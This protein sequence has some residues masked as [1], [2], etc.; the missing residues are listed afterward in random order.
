VCEDH[1]LSSQPPQGGLARGGLAPSRRQFLYGAGA[2]AAGAALLRRPP[3]LPSRLPM[4]SAARLVSPDGSSAYSMAMHVHS[5]FSEQDGSMDAQLF[6]ATTNSVDVLW[7]SDHDFRM[8]GTGYRDTVHF[9]SLTKENGAPGQGSAWDWQA[10]QSGPLS[11]GSGGGIVSSP[12]TPNDPSPHGSLSLT[13]QTT[14]SQAASFG[15]Y[16]NCKDAGYNYRDNLTGQSLSIDVL[17]NPGWVNG[18]L[19]LEIGTSYHEASAGRPAGDYTLAYQIIPGN[20]GVQSTNVAN[21][22]IITIPLGGPGGPTVTLTPAPGGSGW[23]TVTITPSDDIASLWPDLDYRDFALWELTLSAVSTG[24]DVSGYFDYLNFGRTITGGEF[25]AQQADMMT[26]LANTYPDV[27]QQQGL[28]ISWKLPHV[29]WFGGSVVIPN[30]GSPDPAEWSTYLENVLVPQI[31]EAGG[32]VS[33]NHPYGTG[34]GPLLPTEEQDTLLGQI[35]TSML[36]TASAPAALGT[37]LLEVGYVSRGSADLTHHVGLW[38]VMSRNS[39]FLTGSGVND[40]HTGQGWFGLVNNWITSVWGA[41]MAQSDL[42]AALT[43]GQAWCGSL[44]EFGTGSLDL[45]VDGSCP[46]GS[47]SLSSLTSRQL[48]VYATGIPANG[49]VQVLQGT[50][51]Y[52]GTADPQP[53]TAVIASFTAADLASGQTSLA[54]DTSAESFVRTQVLDASGSVI[55]LSNPAWLLQNVPP[56]GI[57]GPRGA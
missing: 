13:A 37:D 25:F 50:V 11:S 40:D 57:P 32:L 36:P 3:R 23:V 44:S 52:A 19:E 12:V 2:L 17:L 48:T 24:D 51:D 35:A 29:N 45:L 30:Y 6:Q 41:S 18:Y 46:M 55:A 20:S 5:S 34:T 31:H 42:L 7:W 14:G 1:G 9:T 16:A 33:Y 4:R 27:S 21:E 53:D 43:A 26:A 38:D 39:V 22:G 49:S 8:D 47:V 15:Y 56:D 28:E 54:V 10:Q